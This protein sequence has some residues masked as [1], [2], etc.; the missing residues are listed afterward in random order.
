MTEERI[1]LAQRKELVALMPVVWDHFD[2][3]SPSRA[4]A[5]I[6]ALQ[7][8]ISAIVCYKAIEASF[9][10]VPRPPAARRRQPKSTSA[11][12][13][14]VAHTMRSLRRSGT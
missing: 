8:P 4:S 10:Q 7:R 11:Q 5:Y 6:T 1:T 2:L 12:Q 14:R 13:S 9:K 3:S